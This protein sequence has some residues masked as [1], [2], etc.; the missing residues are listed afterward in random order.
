MGVVVAV[1][2][3]FR[4]PSTGSTLSFSKKKRTLGQGAF[5]FLV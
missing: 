1:A 2:P 3:S 4:P 5:F